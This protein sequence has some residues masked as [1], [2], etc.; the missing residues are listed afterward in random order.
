MMSQ[1]RFSLVLGAALAAMGCGVSKSYV[2]HQT[3]ATFDNA[4]SVAAHVK[5]KCGADTGDDCKQ[6]AD[7]LAAVCASLDELDKK[8]GG[9]GYDCAAWKA[10][11]P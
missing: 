3:R 7:K 2:T 10:N 5:A 9:A 11:G 4:V 1:M 6:L 8:A